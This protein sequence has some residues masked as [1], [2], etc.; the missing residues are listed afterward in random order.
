MAHNP[1]KHEV[2]FGVQPDMRVIERSLQDL[3]LE[4]SRV[5]TIPAFDRSDEILELLQKQNQRWNAM[6]ENLQ[7]LPAIDQYLQMLVQGL[8]P[9]DQRLTAVDQRLTA[10]D[11]RLTAVDQRL[12]AVDQR[13]TAVDQRLTAVDQR[14]TTVDQRLTVVDQRV[15]ALISLK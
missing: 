14:L 3:S 2:S 9:V 10:V 11:Q 15:T 6:E 1:D 13:L 5:L 4:A 7:L 12:T 8:T